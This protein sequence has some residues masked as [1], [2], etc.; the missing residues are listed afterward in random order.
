MVA[1]LS[2][3]LGAAF[4]QPQKK[5]RPQANVFDP[6]AA[7]LSA[8]PGAVAPAQDVG[9]HDAPPAAVPTDPG[10]GNFRD[11][12]SAIESGGRYDALGP[13]TKLGDRAFGKYQVMGSN[14]G[15]WTQ[16]V[17]GRALTPQEFL[18]APEVQ[19]Q[20]FDSIFGGYAAKHGPAGAASMWFTGR[21][22]APNARDV[23]GTTGQQ[24]VEKFMRKYSR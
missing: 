16:Q 19:D 15:P 3:P 17:L 9:Q 6:L 12:I 24:Y 4:S 22:H 11:A 10:G 7:L 23:L 21:P 8:P 18:A 2:S 14:V 1:V 20:V 5:A 13:V